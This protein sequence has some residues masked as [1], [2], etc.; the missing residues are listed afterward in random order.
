MFRFIFLVITLYVC[1]CQSITTCNNEY[2]CALSTMNNDTI[3]CEGFASCIYW[4]TITTS[5]DF[6]ARGSYSAYS[7]MNVISGGDSLCYGESSC[8]NVTYLETKGNTQCHGYR[9]CFGSTI[10][11]TNST[12]S[13]SYIRFDGDESGAFTTLNLYQNTIV[14]ARARLS[15]HGSNVNMYK[16]SIIQ[17]YGFASLNGAALYCEENQTCTIKCHEYGCYNVSSISGNG[18]YAIDCSDN[19]VFN[20]LCHDKD[21]DDVDEISIATFNDLPSFFTNIG[22]GYVDTLLLCSNSSIL[23]TN[24][25]DS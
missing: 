15:M 5:S 24:C 13:E 4:Q 23:G 17:A 7:V 11:R 21:V 14:E 10:E 12:N 19:K 16:S 18:T 1:K 25:G 2:E 9:S 6:Y 20:I 3:Y 22:F 8:K